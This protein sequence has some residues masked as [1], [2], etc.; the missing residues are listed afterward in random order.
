MQAQLR[1]TSSIPSAAMGRGRILFMLFL[2]LGIGIGFGQTVSI[3]ASEPN[4]SEAGLTSGEFTISVS[5]AGLLG[6]L[7]VFLEVDVS[8]TATSGLDYTALPS[9][10]NVSIFF[11]SGTET[12]EVEVLQDLLVEFD[13][14]VTV[15]I[16]SNAN[17]TVAPGG[18]S[19]TVT[20]SSDD[21]PDG[22]CTNLA[23]PNLD[24][25]EPTVFCEAIFVDLDNYVNNVNGPGGTQLVWSRNPSPDNVDDQIDSNIE[26]GSGV[27][28]GF[29]YDNANDCYGASLE[30]ELERN[31]TPEI[32]ETTAEQICGSGTSVLTVTAEVEDLSAITYSWFDSLDANASPVATGTTFETGELTETTSFY[33]SAA[34][35]ECASEREEVVVTVNN[36]PLAGAPID[37]LQAC[38]VSSDDGPNTFDLDEGLIGQDPGTWTI[39][40]DPSEGNVTIGAE[41]IVDFT[42]L[43]SG[44]YI[45]EYTTNTVGNCTE[46][47]SAQI[48]IAVQDCISN[49][50][51]DLAITK[52]VEGRSAYLLGE[53]IVFVINVEN[54]DENLV[55]DIVVTDILDENFEFLGA[56]PSLGNYNPDTGEWIIPEMTPTDSN[57]M[58]T[59]T[60]R[61]RGPGDIPNTV[62]L[63]SSVPVD[64]NPENNSDTVTVNVNRSECV[65]P[66]T[67]C[68]IFSPN[69]DGYND[70]LTLVGD[71]L[72]PNNTFE[73]F[74]RYGNSVFQMDGYDSS[75]NG[76]GKNGDLPKG[77]YFYVLDLNGDGT[78]VS[79]GWIQIVR[80]N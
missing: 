9:S 3:T 28:Y 63:V 62:A 57:A 74:D 35:N 34:S 66:G 65:Y 20:I 43:P 7:E 22:T 44:D 45:F 1:T 77:T 24:A 64:G 67:I 11:G 31:F 10:E 54:V 78:D 27:Y 68:N 30:L 42:G 71:H 38:N 73:I 12:L 8:S 16:V 25:T 56:E 36:E 23:A 51:I 52:T 79:K 75:W 70:T 21:V 46:T 55:M 37:G 72:F 17:Y 48:T 14:T 58:L 2:L 15:N 26:D 5:N 19:A 18:G 69:G 39:I 40:T 49:E 41:N 6:S 61:A 4:A 76:T 47:A 80:D 60:V 53:E 29:Y 59:I 13:E 50:A 33:V 32:V